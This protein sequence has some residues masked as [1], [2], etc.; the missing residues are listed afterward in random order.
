[1]LFR[2]ARFSFACFF[3]TLVIGDISYAIGTFLFSCD[4]GRQILCWFLWIASMTVHYILHPTWHFIMKHTLLHLWWI[5]FIVPDQGILHILHRQFFMEYNW[6]PSIPKFCHKRTRWK[7]WSN[8]LYRINSSLLIMSGCIMIRKADAY[9]FSDYV[10]ASTHKWFASSYRLADS[11]LQQPWLWFMNVLPTWP[12]DGILLKVVLSCFALAICLFITGYG[13]VRVLKARF[14][15]NAAGTSFALVN[16]PFQETPAESPVDLLSSLPSQSTS[17][18][19]GFAHHRPIALPEVPS[20]STAMKPQTPPSSPTKESQF[21]SEPPSPNTDTA[22]TAHYIVTRALSTKEGL[23]QHRHRNRSSFDNDAIRFVLDNCAN[24]HIVNDP[25][26][27]ESIKP[28]TTPGVATIG[29]D[30]LTPTGQRTCHMYIKNDRGDKI[31]VRLL[32]ALYFPQSPVNIISIAQFSDMYEDTYETTISTARYHSDFQWD[33]GKHR[34]TVHHSLTRIP[35]IDVFPISDGWKSFYSFS[36]TFEQSLYAKA[37]FHTSSDATSLDDQ[38]TSTEPNYISDDEN[39]HDSPASQKIPVHDGPYAQ[40]KPG[41]KLKYCRD[42]HVDEV[43]VEKILLSDDNLSI[44]YNIRLTDGREITSTKEFYDDAFAIPTSVDEYH[45]QAEK[46]DTEAIQQLMHPRTL[47]PLEQEFMDSHHSLQH[48]PYTEMFR[49]AEFGHLPKRFLRLKKKPP[50]CASCIFSS[51]KRKAWKR[52]HERSTTVR[53]LEHNRPGKGTSIDQLVSAQPGLVPRI[54][55][56]HTRQRIYAATVFLDHYSDFS[57]THLCVSTSQDETLKAKAAY[58]KLAATHGVSVKHYHADNGRFAEKGFRDVVHASNQT[59]SFCAVNAHHQNG[60]IENFIG[61]LERGG[62]I[63]LLHAKRHW[64]EAIGTILWP[65]AI[66]AYEDR[67]NHWHL[68]KDGKS[69]IQKFSST[70]HNQEIKNWHTFGCPVFILEEKAVHGKM[71]K[72]NPRSRVGI[73][74][75]HS[76]CH[77]GSVA[78]VLNPKT[79]HVSPQYHVVFDDQF[80]TVSYMKNGEIPPHWEDLVMLHSESVT[81]EKIHLANTWADT[82]SPEM[83]KDTPLTDDVNLQLSRSYNPSHGSL[84]PFAS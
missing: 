33:F 19:I 35:E 39:S 67:R 24:V 64:P 78:L 8:R 50:M 42:G 1:M 30:P 18:L 27:F 84:F 65:F 57:Y 48:A 59:I 63:L 3:H 54:S 69:P 40:W 53:K 71:P 66:K 47:T 20:T 4:F 36:N 16:S 81:N 26:I 9:I 49:L 11:C 10:P 79:L 61:Q 51:M 68:D 13:Y 14:R 32:N 44:R 45:A 41:Q 73:Y 58:E 72:W 77:A 80:T 56:R 83:T 15:I 46:L 22:P 43:I 7:Y 62:R 6:T 31:P 29:G 37:A 74:L 17:P 12:P 76:P 70:Y 38:H 75:G 5:T 52:G 55:G 28:P 21:L 25:E 23:S 34:K 2:M 60:L 82:L